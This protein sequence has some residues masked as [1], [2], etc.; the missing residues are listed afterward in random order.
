MR[1]SGH[2]TSLDSEIVFDFYCEVCRDYGLNNEANG[3][4]TD[5]KEY[6]C[7]SC[8]NAHKQA[9]PTRHHDL[10]DQETMPMDTPLPQDRVIKDIASKCETHSDRTVEHYCPLHDKL[11]CSTC[12]LNDHK[13]CA[14]IESILDK[15]QNIL[16][17]KYYKDFAGSLK[18]MIHMSHDMIAKTNENVVRIERC[19]SDV[20]GQLKDLREE[21][22]AMFDEL[23]QTL[24]AMVSE[25]NASMARLKEELKTIAEA[26]DK[27]RS[28]CEELANMKRVCQLYIETKK[29]KGEMASLGEHLDTLE[30]NIGV[31]KFKLEPNYDLTDR[32]RTY[33]L[34][35]IAVA[36]APSG[37]TRSKS[38]GGAI[39]NVENTI[40]YHV[41]DIDVSTSVYHRGNYITGSAVMSSS[42]I[43]VTDFNYKKVKLLDT[44]TQRV[45]SEL[46]VPDYPFDIAF[47]SENQVAVTLSNDKKILLIKVEDTLSIDTEIPVQGICRGVAFSQNKLLVTF[48]DNPRLEILDLQGNVIKT[49]DKDGDGKKVFTYPRHVCVG[50]SGEVIY[51]SDKGANKVFCLTFDGRVKL[52]FTGIS[53]PQNVCAYSCGY[54]FV[55][56]SHSR[57]VHMVTSDFSR[58][59]EIL[60]KADGL[61]KSLLSV[62]FCQRTNRLYVG[63]SESPIIKVYQLS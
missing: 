26:L 23:E 57:T 28:E 10:L 40:A 6:L 55:A 42:R 11:G 39:K 19:C 47:I 24:H 44:G 9:R 27:I 17:S 30:G 18:S 5:C 54:L 50:N 58:S 34:G 35:T 14:G 13:N 52:V 48:K 8:I 33:G 29:S 37:D 61:N 49:I 4:C 38:N 22:N 3:Y 21:F 43:A 56:G 2:G 60:S 12:F 16:H 32:L 63:L 62:T 45:V 53:D 25:E 15:S 51:V 59:Q 36:N 41:S 20:K 1:T 46:S 31:R 7:D